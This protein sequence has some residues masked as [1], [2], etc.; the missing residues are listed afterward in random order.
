MKQK[1]IIA[2]DGSKSKSISGGAW[3][4]A[5]MLGKTFISGTNPDFGHIDQIHSHRA[6]IYGVLSVFIFIQKHSK[7][8]ILSFQ[9]KGAYYCDNLEVINKINTLVNNP[10]SFNKQYITTDHDAVLQLKECLPTNITAF[11]V[12][13]YQDKWKKW[14]YITIPERLNIQADELIGD[15]AKTPLNKHILHTS[16]ANYVKGKYIPNNYVNT[17]CSA[18]LMRK[19]RWNKS[20]IS[21]IEWELQA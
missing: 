7:Y 1:L 11:H 6:E 4:I 12:K 8:Y 3:I 21:D 10:N 18:F 9:S 16:M 19:H 5:D 17:I 20:T 2:S 13:G 14:E 15:N